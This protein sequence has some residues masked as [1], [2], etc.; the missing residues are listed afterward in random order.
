MYVENYIFFM[1]W[2][3]GHGT[4]FYELHAK[5][6]HMVFLSNTY[7]IIFLELEFPRRNFFFLIGAAKVSLV[8][9][10]SEIKII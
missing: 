7:K 3:A 5:K 6:V 9:P 10:N 2:M 1:S 4:H 8:F